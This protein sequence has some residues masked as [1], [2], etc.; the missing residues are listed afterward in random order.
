MANRF[1]R[2]ILDIET[3]GLIS[4][5]IDYTT[6]PM[7][8]KPHAKLWCISLRDF[9]N[10]QDV[11]SLRREEC[12]EA[13]LKALLKDTKE[14]VFHNGI[15]FDMVMLFM[16]G[17]LNY[18]VG[19]E[20]ESDTIFGDQ[21]I[22]F[23]DTLVLSKLLRQDR[24]G[25]HSVEAWGRILGVPKID[26]SDFENYSEEMVT[27]CE[28]DTLTQAA[29]YQALLDE[30]GEEGWAPI[31]KAYRM[32]TKL[33]DLTVRQELRGFYF[34]TD[35]AEQAVID[36]QKI[37]EDLTDKVDPLLPPRP[38]NKGEQKDFVPPKVQFKKDG[39]ISANMIKFIAK[40]GAEYQ[41]EENTITFEGV[42][43]NLPL[44]ECIKTTLPG[45]ID[46]L[47]H[48]KAYLLDLG[49]EPMEWKERD[50]TK[51][52]KKV[53]LHG[54][55]LDATIMRYVDST[56]NGPFKK[57]RLALL[58]ITDETKL[59]A[60]LFGLKDKFS[61]MVPVS[62][63]IRIGTEKKLCDN[64]TKMGEQAEFALDVTQY[65]TFKHR[66]NS[67]AGGKEDE[68]GSPLT[69]YLSQVR[70]DH[71][72]ST[73]AD[74]L[75]A[76]GGR[77]KHRG[78][79]NVPRVSSPGG[80][81]L[82]NLFGCGPERMQ[83]GF[84]FAS[85][86]ARIQGHFVL[87]YT[88]GEALAESLIAE[89]PNDCFDYNTR[90]LSSTGWVH[91]DEVTEDTLI[92][93]WEPTSKTITYTK[94]TQIIKRYHN[95]TNGN[96]IQVK[97]SR[98]D[99][100]VTPNHRVILFNR[101]LGEYVTILAKDLKNYVI[102]NP[103][104]FI[105]ANGYE[106]VFD[107][108]G[109]RICNDWDYLS[110]LN[111]ISN[112]TTT[113]SG[114]VVLQSE[115]RSTIEAIALGQVLRGSS[116]MV[117]DKSSKTKEVYQTTI[118]TKPLNEDGFKLIADEITEVPY[119]GD[120]W[121]VSVPST[122]VLARRNGKIFV[123]GNCHTINANKLGITR[124]NAKAFSYASMYGAQ[125]EKLA[126]MLRIP[127]KEAERLFTAYWDAVPALKEL[128]ERVENFWKK[129]GKQYIVGIDGRKLFVRS[130]H[131]L[132]NLLFQSA[133]ALCVKYT[134]VGINRRLE[135]LGMLGNPLVDTDEDMIR[136]VYMM[137]VY[138]DEAQFDCPDGFFKIHRFE[139]EEEAEQVKATY[140]GSS[141][142][143]HDDKG[144]YFCE[145][146]LV[147]RFIDEEIFRVCMDLDLR[148][149]LGM[150]YIVGTT[151]AECH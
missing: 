117:L 137:I 56:L 116:A 110:K 139:T 66:K 131:S 2:V 28:G 85:L 41:E 10:Q 91:M 6:K 90:L 38:L 21:P 50:L 147:S 36:F 95:L 148:V 83:L 3:N 104:S 97:G 119:S 135:E 33:V 60:Y 40:V 24:P 61:L 69:G 25:G 79:C 59:A 134:I 37:L 45:S 129:T 132:V 20:G 12:T 70:T 102:E 136:M 94:P 57:Y 123:S 128:K 49:W 68:E 140:K 143:G 54:E 151:W 74:T 65:L 46:N 107:A 98:L 145:E 124:D 108:E 30:L 63:L 103:E 43:Y 47:D 75:G 58:G 149:P 127:L 126:K 7:R 72:I 35:A 14:L 150:E 105:P 52:S 146:N 26:F 82:R 130:Q 17:T 44:T 76:N 142:V 55:K 122:Y 144:Y 109:K 11:V 1:E 48:L 93:N 27:Y 77:Y 86:E 81:V 18:R 115:D 121:C 13:N 73:P 141:A 111:K 106:L 101:T 34:N 64:L 16:F 62:P 53:K 42:T 22:K 92:A 133:G 88:D 19:Y 96:M 138:H 89:K 99:M 31:E 29:I 125:P 39:T 5:L 8:L 71:R 87:P 23:V 114:S 113:E 84:D 78:V 32:E 112:M 80:Q 9:D 120:V 118:H 15:S 51:D 4:M 100:L 67:I